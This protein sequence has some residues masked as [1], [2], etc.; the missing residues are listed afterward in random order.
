MTRRHSPLQQFKEAKTIARSYG[1]FVVE[2]PACTGTHYLLYRTH[3]EGNVF[4]GRRSSPQGIRALVCK[5]T[6]FH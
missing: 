5:V 4:V 3:T 6:N 2:K 1:L